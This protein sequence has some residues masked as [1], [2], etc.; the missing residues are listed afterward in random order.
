MS[1]DPENTGGRGALAK[2]HATAPPTGFPPKETILDKAIGPTIHRHPTSPS[3]WQDFDATVTHPGGFPGHIH[4]SIHPDGRAV[5]V[6]YPGGDSI[7]IGAE[8]LGDFAALLEAIQAE[9]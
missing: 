6:S 2:E 7:V 5:T 8:H 9:L 4:A 3:G 1:A